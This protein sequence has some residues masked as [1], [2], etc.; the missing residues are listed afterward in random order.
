MN[1]QLQRGAGILLPISSLPS[2]YGIGTLG[3]EAYEFID[4]LAEAKQTYWQVLPVGP[5]S[6]GDSP[7]QSFSAY[8]G[9]PYFIDLTMLID[10]EL[11]EEKS[12]ASISFGDSDEYISY[13]KLWEHRY[14]VLREAYQN[15]ECE[16]KKEYKTF[17]KN[18][19]AWL[20][21]Y[22]LFMAVKAH[23]GH[24]SWLMWEEPIRYRK[25]NAVKKYKSLL[26]EEIGFYKFLQFKFYEQWFALK[27]YANKK[28]IKLIG[29]IPIYVA[30]D[31][32]DV[33]AN[34]KQFQLNENLEPIHVAG[35]PP[36]AF[37]DMGQKW[38]NPL[39]DWERMEKED[40]AWWK[41]RM[42]AATK[43]FDVV[44]ID[45]FIGIVRY[46]VIP[47]EK[48]AKDGWYNM[49]PGDKLIKAINSVIGDAKVIAEDLGVLV[50]KVE[51]VLKRSGYPGMKVLEFAFDGNPNNPY[52]PH[53]YE[54]NCVVYGGTHDNDTL[55]GYYDLL[56]EEQLEYAM[57][58]CGVEKREELVDRVIRMAYQCVADTVIFQMQDLLHKD[59]QAR[60]NFPSTIGDNWRWRMQKGEF[61]KKHIEF[62]KELT[63]IYGREN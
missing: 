61:T 40:F 29:D 63:I 14:E 57:K 12:V 2:P 3:K 30:L 31:S 35:C 36:D 11:L 33:W 53:T 51:K 60:M 32:A 52:L 4:Q 18:H 34:P 8:A 6:Y 26:K 13:E 59:N 19:K 20:E 39:Y 5:T 45:H 62:L 54:K 47:A 27:A 25:P 24:K 49:G 16:K 37:S 50:P 58:Y 38:G 43:L 21:D 15:S 44:R 10:E 56:P 22:A 1:K 7:Y 55:E 41:D 48:T 46:Y 9:N 42:I 28:K 23:F 17:C